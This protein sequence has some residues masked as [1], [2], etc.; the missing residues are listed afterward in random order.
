MGLPSA[1]LN[2]QKQIDLTMEN[3]YTDLRNTFLKKMSIEVS[4]IDLPKGL[5]KAI[6]DSMVKVADY[7]EAEVQA[8]ISFELLT[9]RKELREKIEKRLE[10]FAYKDAVFA[11]H[12]V[13]DLLQDTN[14]EE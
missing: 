2:M 3:K 9:Q 14:K 13:L 10:E 1:S 8:V 12:D 6:F 5:D 7:W 11:Y 4:Q